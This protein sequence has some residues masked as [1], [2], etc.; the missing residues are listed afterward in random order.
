MPDFEFRV[1]TVFKTLEN[2]AL[3]G[4]ALFFPEVSFFADDSVEI[5]RHVKIQ[6]RR[7]VKES[8]AGDI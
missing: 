1:W 2:E 3:L 4:E 6:V 8:P 5:Q 7:L